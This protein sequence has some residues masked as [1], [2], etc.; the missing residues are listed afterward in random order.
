MDG[1]KRLSSTFSTI[2]DLRATILHALGAE[3]DDSAMVDGKSLLPVL[4]GEEKSI[5]DYIL[6]GI[7]GTGC[8]LTTWDTT[9]IRGFNAKKP[10]H[11]YSS[12]FSMFMSPSVISNLG[13]VLGVKIKYEV[14]ENMVAQLAK[15]IDTGFFIPGVV[16]PQW[17]IPIPSVFFSAMV[18]SK[19][20]KQNYLF[21][22][23]ED[24]NFQN[25]LADNEDYKELEQN[26]NQKMR[27][28][29][30]KEGCPPEQFERLMLIEK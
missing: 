18:D 29:L 24:P 11:W 15:Q 19:E 25:N 23:K 9:Y 12:S 5:R 22:R 21:N 1:K 17:K 30:K 6:Y 14:A 7:F 13:E 10:L 2:V 16:F 20:Q 4:S 26:M 8:H 27:E 28:I 3:K